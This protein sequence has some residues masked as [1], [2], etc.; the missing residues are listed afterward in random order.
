[1]A[2]GNLCF[3]GWPCVQ[4]FI[5][6]ISYIL[7]E[8]KDNDSSLPL[9]HSECLNITSIPY[10]HSL[11]L[12]ENFYSISGHRK[13]TCVLCSLCLI[14]KRKLQQW[15]ERLMV[16]LRLYAWICLLWSRNFLFIYYY[17]WALC[18]FIYQWSALQQILG[19]LYFSFL[20]TRFWR[21]FMRHSFGNMY[22]I[23]EDDLKYTEFVW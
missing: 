2:T 21:Q 6:W 16:A 17:F 9:L 22:Y 12:A 18:S 11:C 10:L 23:C 7:S 1:M 19:Y 8:K 5:I 13:F 4:V 20:R 14:K 3:Q 15:I